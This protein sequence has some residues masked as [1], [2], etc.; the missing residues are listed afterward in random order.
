LREA[1]DL[2]LVETADMLHIPLFTAE[3][4]LKH[5]GDFLSILYPTFN[6]LNS[7]DRTGSVFFRGRG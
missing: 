1:K 2:L 5:F 7:S 4:M 6:G 3:A